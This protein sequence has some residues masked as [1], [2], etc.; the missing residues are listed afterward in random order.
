MQADKNTSIFLKDKTRLGDFVKIQGGYAFQ[1]ALFRK[2]GIPI[3]RISNIYGSTIDLKNSAVYYDDTKVIGDDFIAKKDDLLIAMSG[4][5]TGK[6]G[7]YPYQKC[8]YVNQRVGKF[9]LCKG[10]KAI[11]KYITYWTQSNDFERQLSRS[12]VAGAQPNISPKNIEDMELFLPD[13]TEQQN[14][15]A[16]LDAI[17]ANITFLQHLIS[18]QENIKKSTINLLLAPRSNWQEIKLGDICSITTGKLDANAMS[19]HGKYAFF[20]CAKEVYKINN[21]AFD[22]EALLVSGNGSHVGYVHYYK[23]RFN[24]YQRTYVLDKFTANILFVK[25]FLDCKLSQRIDA[26][27]KSGNT[28]YIL[29]DTLYDMKLTI[30]VSITEQERIATQLSEIDAHIENLKQQLAKQRAIKQGLMQFF[31]GD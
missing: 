12:L 3:I 10:D 5:T 16:V 29:R 2:R 6:C 21:Y 11:Y 15:V 23:G 13:I 24:A 1:S 30:P 22:T 27:K 9:T 14:V 28:P 19:P 26:E 18:K 4:A 25:Y 8:A 31:F 7:V 20:T 17:S